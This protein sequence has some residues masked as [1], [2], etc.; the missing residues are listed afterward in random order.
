MADKCMYI[1][2]DDAQNY[3][4]CNMPL[5]NMIYIVAAVTN[6][7]LSAPKY[8]LIRLLAI[9]IDRSNENGKCYGLKQP[10]LFIM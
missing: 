6:G 5:Q 10:Q 2:N 1:P 8:Y 9:Q 4:F 7:F 3:P